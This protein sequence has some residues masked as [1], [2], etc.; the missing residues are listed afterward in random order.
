M[1]IMIGKGWAIVPALI[2]HDMTIIL[3]ISCAIVCF[4]IWVQG[5]LSIVVSYILLFTIAPF[6]PCFIHH[7]KRTTTTTWIYFLFLAI[8][9]GVVLYYYVYAAE[10][11]EGMVAFQASA[12]ALNQLVVK[13]YSTQPV[14]KLHD[15]L[16]FDAMNGNVLELFGTSFTNNNVDMTGDSLRY[17]TVMNRTP[18]RLDHSNLYQATTTTVDI[19][20]TADSQVSTGLI[21]NSTASSYAPWVY[22]IQLDVVAITAGK[23]GHVTSTIPNYQVLYIP[24]G[25]ETIVEVYDYTKSMPIGTYYFRENGLDPMHVLSQCTVA[26]PTTYMGNTDIGR[27]NTYTT[28]DQYEHGSRS[29]FQVSDNVWFD[30][31]NRFLIIRNP[32]GTFTVYNG[33]SDS[34]GPIKVATNAATVQDTPHTMN[35]NMEYNALYMSDVKGA[36]VVLYVPVSDSKTLVAILAVEPTNT[37]LLNLKN[38]VRFNTAS[39][40]GVDGMSNVNTPTTNTNGNTNGGYNIDSCYNQLDIKQEVQDAIDSYFNQN[41]S[42]AP[43]IAG[44]GMGW[45]G[46]VSEDY[47]LKT[48]VWPP[49]IPPCP[50]CPTCPSMTCNQHPPLVAGQTVYDASYGYPSGYQPPST[51]IVSSG[52]NNIGN[53]V[54]G[55]GE[56]LGHDVGNVVNKGVSAGERVGGDVLGAGEKV[57]KGVYNA[58][59]EVLDNVWDEAKEIGRDVRDALRFHPMDAGRTPTT[60]YNNSGYAIYR[61]DASGNSYRTTA[62]GVYVPM[63]AN[64]TGLDY[65]GRSSPSSSSTTSSNFIPM[66][67]DFSKFGR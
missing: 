59:G 56:R 32:D 41:Y 19:S 44:M 23:E 38:V 14:Y 10:K 51:G 2:E 22:P 4:R 52:V 9:L 46:R 5:N 61:D 37:Q 48:S 29:I 7:M 50:S 45:G 65:M 24:W 47:V 1:M 6:H 27:L 8:F 35:T 66:L 58:T 55:L 26:M 57:A 18:T 62:N 11:Y 12:F 63:G 42:G 25:K 67:D 17:V 21:A 64:K 28:L 13:K 54:L 33:A 15:S 36:N 31:S 40:N 16:Y 3:G 60:S 43:G 30:T 34:N 49:T 39:N 53:S 20:G